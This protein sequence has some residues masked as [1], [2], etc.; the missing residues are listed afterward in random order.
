MFNFSCLAGQNQNTM[1]KYLFPHSAQKIAIVVFVATLLTMFV[2]T[3]ILARNQVS[4]NRTIT[5]ILGITLQLSLLVAIL[6]K[7]KIEDE[8]ISS[9]R[10]KAISIAAVLGFV[11]III[12]NIIQM[13]LPTEA[14]LPFKEWRINHFWNGRLYMHL[15]LLYFVI[16][17]ISLRKNR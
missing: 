10:L 16:L 17:K 15:A 5:S 14:Y 4:Y 12:L 11:Y 8:F 13:L 6:S 9:V 1:K 7:E 2:M 3:F